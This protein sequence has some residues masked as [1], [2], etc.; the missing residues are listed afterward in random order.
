MLTDGRLMAYAADKGDKLL[1]I[2]TGQRSG[3]GPPMTWSLDGRQY[4]TLMGGRG[5]GAIRRLVVASAAAGRLG[6][7]GQA[8]GA[9]GGQAPAAGGRGNPLQPGP[10]V[11]PRMLTFVLD[12]KAPLPSQ[13]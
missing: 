11:P 4:V 1:E 13:P 6:R 5:A 8:P 12:G 7:G 9:G 2:Q 10:G 3:M